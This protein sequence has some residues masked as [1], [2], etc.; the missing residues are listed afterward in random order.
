MTSP[1]STKEAWRHGPVVLGGGTFGGIGGNLGFLGKGMDEET[2]FA[3][4]DEAAS[5]GITLFDTAER[6]A[7]GESERIIGRWLA[8]R[9]SNVTGPI[10]VS[11]KVGPPWLDGREGRFDNDYIRPI[12]EGSLERLGV[13]SVDVLYTHAPDDHPFSP[14]AYEPVPIEVTLEALEE[15]RSSGQTRLIGASNINLQ[16]LSTAMEAA[17]RIGVAGYQVIQNGF[18]LLHPQ[19]D[20]ELRELARSSGIAYTAYSALASGVLTGKYRRDEP[21]PAGSLV[22]LGYLDGIPDDVYDAVDKLRSEASDRRSVPGALALAWLVAHD[23]VTA[24][25]TAPSR[26]APHLSLVAEAI[27]LP[28]SREDVSRWSAWFEDVE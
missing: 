9:P 15:V 26:T 27:G 6:Y 2:S 10:Q 28:V 23:D 11:T 17:D 8:S 14:N 25:T 21:P 1:R 22:D 4:M 20:A 7:A 5:L 13:E 24:L 12:F 19:E 18:N 16:Q 3:A